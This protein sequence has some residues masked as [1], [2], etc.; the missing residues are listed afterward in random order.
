MEAGPAGR[1]MHPGERPGPPAEDGKPSVADTDAAGY[2]D[3][4][5]GSRVTYATGWAAFEAGKDIQRQM[6]DKVAALW[7]V[8]PDE[9]VYENGPVKSKSDAPKKMTFKEIPASTPN[10]RA[11]LFTPPT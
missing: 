10:H 3:V 2:T 11:V 8:Q 5:G 7:K 1:A 4:T 6:I 9:L